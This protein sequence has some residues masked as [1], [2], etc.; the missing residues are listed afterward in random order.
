[1]KTQSSVPATCTTSEAAKELGISVRAAQ[2]WVENGVLRAW[3]T[4]GGHRR[5][6]RSSLSEVIKQ[7]H[8][9]PH[10]QA[11]DAL[12][13]LIIEAVRSERESLGSA[14]LSSFPGSQVK[15]AMSALESLLSIGEQAP[16]I[17]IANLDVLDVECIQGYG[18][19]QNAHLAG[20]LVIGLAADLAA[21]QDI[22]RQLPSE[23]I[24]LGKSSAFE[25]LH[26]LVRAFIQ[27]RQNQR[28]KA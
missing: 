7:Q 26:A 25:Q 11:G 6:L 3:K 13:I 16:D 27:G 28:R 20:T 4:P 1:M 8:G 9:V 23:F 12:S 2:L 22:C 21:M 15:L 19:A 5:I 18:E 24:L 17:L 10:Q 14:L